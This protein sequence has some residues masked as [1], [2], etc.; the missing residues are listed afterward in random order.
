MLFVGYGGNL[1]GLAPRGCRGFQADRW[2]GI[3]RIS[4]V[5]K[6]TILRR[7]TAE[8]EGA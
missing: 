3:L 8:L 5:N 6:L 1:L 4:A 7:R 2:L